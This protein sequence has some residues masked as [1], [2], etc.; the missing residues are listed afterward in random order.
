MKKVPLVVASLVAL[1]LSPAPRAQQPGS[2]SIVTM[3]LPTNHPKVSRNLS[4]LWLAP[5][6]GRA[7]ER[8]SSLT[9][10]ISAMR[11]YTAGDYAKALPLFSQK[12]VQQGPLGDYAA[13]Y[14]GVASFRLGNT[15]EARRTF[16]ALGERKPVGYLVVAGALGEAEASEAADDY[17]AAEVI[18]ERLL[19]A[20]LGALDDIWMRLGK[21]AKAAGQTAR[22]ADAFAR[23]YYEFPL[24]ELA[25]S[26][27]SELQSLPGLEAITPGLPRYKLE[28][29]RAERLFGAH[30]YDVARS[31]FEG[32][33][34][35]ALEDDA[36]LVGLR[37]AECDYFLKRFRNARAG[38]GP[39]IEH[40]SRQA[41]A[42][43]FDAL[44]SRDLKDEAAYTKTM[45]RVADEFP[46]E[47]WAEDALD[48]L[49][50][51]YILQDD[52]AKADV[53]FREMYDKYPK[54]NHAERAA[55][56]IGWRSYSEARYDETIQYFERAAG[57]FPRSD[58]RPPW[59][60]WA[61]RAHEQANHRAMADERYML[62]AADY[63]NSYYGR[64]AVRRLNGRTPS[65]RVMAASA[66]GSAGVGGGNETAVTLP[67]NGQ[68]VRALLDV[69]L[70]DDAVEELR[71]AQRRWGDGPAI[72]ATLAWVYRQ[73]SSG[74]TGTQ[75]FT[76]LRGS[77][78]AMKRAY[79]QFLAAGGEEL[80]RDVLT[81]IFP[82]AY[83]D[84]IQKYSAQHDLDPYLVAAL[85]AQEST[86]V[87]DIV[88]SAK[89]VGLMQ[90][91]PSTARQYARKLKLPYSAKL[92][93]NP[94]AN[95]RMGT[96]YLADKINEF[97]GVHLALASYNAGE[98]PVHR[99]M[100][101]HP[102]DVDTSEFIDDIPFPQTQNYVK[103]IL[104]TA[105]DYRRLYSPEAMRGDAADLGMMRTTR[106]VAAKKP[107]VAPAK[108]APARRTPARR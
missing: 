9:D 64:L 108:K 78:T 89:A 107:A 50:T 97:G 52:D 67:P 17:A 75:Q 41:E 61:G 84:L 47:T 62:A 38:L 94:D 80:P 21:A 14:A 34:S 92:L 1:V 39:F 72:Q 95:I 58:Y 29:G 18:Y 22:A 59:L 36:E 105:D 93:R 40:A 48:S 102:S 100:A 69:E 27:G 37:L 20:N 35:S 2:S 60:Y 73:Q 26:A 11:L 77:I 74:L 5:E 68:V 88:S 66:P 104:G 81:I 13:Y 44:A 31:V 24:S 86:F 51:S 30:Q 53:V 101:E 16:H 70:F 33:R 87:A 45:R 4:D 15:S 63:L 10:F 57:D 32:L 91:L 99:W 43:Y 82:L 85:M 79:P 96:A 7:S 76:L 25:S 65:P 19:D 8:S 90:M 42:L 54:G 46:A 12:T 49:A 56:K 6:K 71:F 23:V 106:P 28:L 3:L 103:K 98:R 55:W 83:W